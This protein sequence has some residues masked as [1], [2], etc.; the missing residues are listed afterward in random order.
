MKNETNNKDYT[1]ATDSGKLYITTENFFKQEEIISTIK[2]LL[3]SKIIKQ[4]ENTNNIDNSSQ[5]V[6]VG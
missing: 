2:E 1:E 3:G 5:S 6:K 4:I